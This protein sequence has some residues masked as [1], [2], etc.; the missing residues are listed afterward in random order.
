LSMVA[1]AHVEIR[2]ARADLDSAVSIDLDAESLQ[3][4]LE[5]LIFDLLAELFALNEL[6]DLLRRFAFRSSA[7]Q[8][9]HTIT[10]HMLHSTDVDEALYVMLSGSTSGYALGF[11]R[12]ALFV[13][14]RTDAAFGTRDGEP[15]DVLVGA[16]AIGPGDETEAF[17]IWE[18]LEAEDKTV[19]DLIADYINRNFDTRFQ[20]RVQTLALEVSLD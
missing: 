13:P 1:G 20:Q 16:K 7:L 11:N 2:V 19:D 14:M 3:S 4:D 6:G 10:H 12:A 15:V 17:R 18:S 9:L 5:H 8:T